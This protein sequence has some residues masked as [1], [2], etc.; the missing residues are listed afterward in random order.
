MWY[1]IETIYH[2]LSESSKL[3]QDEYMTRHDW[4][5]KVI[6][7]ELRKMFKFDH[8]NKWCMHNMECVLENEMHK[9][10]CDFEIQTDHLISGR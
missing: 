5:G 4:A 9:I 3:A 1:R 10:L 6:H 2:I 8:T 7:R